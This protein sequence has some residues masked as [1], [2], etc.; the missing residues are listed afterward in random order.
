MK[1]FNCP[2]IDYFVLYIKKYY[3]NFGFQNCNNDNKNR[4]NCIYR[5]SMTSLYDFIKDIYNIRRH[6]TK[7]MFK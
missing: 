5:K 6:F 4:N 2:K 3:P 7:S 1:S